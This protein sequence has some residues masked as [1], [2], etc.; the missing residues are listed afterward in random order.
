MIIY[1]AQMR[2]LAFESPTKML[3][4]EC[5]R[6]PLPGVIPSRVGIVNDRVATLTDNKFQIHTSAFSGGLCVAVQCELEVLSAVLG[7]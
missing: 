6:C 5:I 3:Y 4:F 1:H 2:L 7:T